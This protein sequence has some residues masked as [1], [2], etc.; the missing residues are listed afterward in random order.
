M[1]LCCGLFLWN[2]AKKAENGIPIQTGSIGME[3]KMSG[4][5][6]AE[7]LVSDVFLFLPVRF[8]MVLLYFF[9]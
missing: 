1:K 3:I 4:T 7:C 6:K 5:D 2:T 9:R 8:V